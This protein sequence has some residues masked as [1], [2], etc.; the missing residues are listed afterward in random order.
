[1]H[2]VC[3]PMSMILFQLDDLQVNLPLLSS[4]MP[5]VLVLI[6]LCQESCIISIVRWWLL[7]THSVS[8]LPPANDVWGKVMFLLACVI[9]FTWVSLYDVTSWSNV[10]SKGGLCLSFHVPSG[11]S[12]SMVGLYLGGLYLGGLC[13]GGLCLGGLCPRVSVRETPKPRPPVWWQA[14]GTHHTGMLSCYTCV[15]YE[16]NVNMWLY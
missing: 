4:V 3:S 15:I 11:G 6:C 16:V 9:L 2:T 7:A 13:L 12:Q 14:G 10:P 8:L 1:M 5:P